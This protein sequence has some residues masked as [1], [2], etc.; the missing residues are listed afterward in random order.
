MDTEP[1][2]IMYNDV[3]NYLHMS[4]IRIK[5]KESYLALEENTMDFLIV[6]LE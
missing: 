4:L 1:P 5:K 3:A 6:L 2:K